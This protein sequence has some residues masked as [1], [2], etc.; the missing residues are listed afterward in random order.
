M[1]VEVCLRS[2]YISAE[3]HG[4]TSQ[5]M[6]FLMLISTRTSN[7]IIILYVVMTGK[8]KPYLISLFLQQVLS[9]LSGFLQCLTT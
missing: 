3:Q 7:L 5:E 8:V 1:V 6:L 9:V 2:W 4:V